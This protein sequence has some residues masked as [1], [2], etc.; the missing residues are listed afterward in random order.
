MSSTTERISQRVVDLIPTVPRGL[1]ERGAIAAAKNLEDERLV[2]LRDVWDG[3]SGRLILG[4]TGAG[5]SLALAQ[6]ARRF[7]LSRS[8]GEDA[9]KVV[10]YRAD[11][12][13]RALG[14]RGG[15]ESV[16]RAKTAALLIIDDLGWERWHET[17]LEVVGSR[18]DGRKV[19]TATTGLKM[20]DFVNRYGDA[21]LRRIV[22]VGDGGAIDLWRHRQME[23]LQLSVGGTA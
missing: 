4:P 8:R 10:W 9:P 18:Y 7:A 3:R 12:L 5:K 1:L 15:T 17:L 23:Q 22:E 11:E 16:S 21:F 2:A 6:A 14:E 20:A 13:A 19:T